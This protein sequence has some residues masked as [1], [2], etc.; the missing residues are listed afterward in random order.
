M[1]DLRARVRGEVPEEEFEES[2]LPLLDEQASPATTSSIE[3]TTRRSNSMSSA[4][5]DPAS[6]ARV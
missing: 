2:L 5:R 3:R 4:F 1:F 6:A